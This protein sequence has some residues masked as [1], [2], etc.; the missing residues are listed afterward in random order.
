MIFMDIEMPIMNGYRS[1][2]LIKE[3]YETF[4]TIET[5][6]QE[7]VEDSNDPADILEGRQSKNNLYKL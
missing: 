1:S 3:A 5:R 2:V 7:Q 6:K 4:K